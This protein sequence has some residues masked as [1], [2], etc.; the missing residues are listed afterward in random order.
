MTKLLAELLRSDYRAVLKA[1]MM[2]QHH[3][4]TSLAR[5]TGF[6]VAHIGNIFKD[7]GSDDAI[8]AICK[9][10]KLDIRKDLFKPE[11]SGKI[12]NQ[13]GTNAKV[14]TGTEGQ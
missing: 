11:S 1:S 3:N 9:I 14:A 5:A 12:S 7:Q 2:E 4:H 13:E 6:S 8:A 10:L